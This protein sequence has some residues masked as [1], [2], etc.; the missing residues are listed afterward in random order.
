MKKNTIEK[1][2]NKVNKNTEIVNKFDNFCKTEK[3]K[4]LVIDVERLGMYDL[5]KK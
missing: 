3:A 1:N 4:T 2:L 5:L